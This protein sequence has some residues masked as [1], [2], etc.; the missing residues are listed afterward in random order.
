MINL[1]DS[2][3]NIRESQLADMAALETLYPSAFPDEDLLPLIRKLLAGRNDVLSLVAD[4][5]DGVVGHV[6]FSTCSV[7]GHERHVSM[8]APLAVDPAIQRQGIGAALVQEGLRRLQRKGFRQVL[9]LGDPGYYGR[10]GFLPETS[11]DPPYP[12]PQDWRGAWQSLSLGQGA[13]KLSGVLCV[14]EPW[15]EEALWLP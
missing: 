10:F 7:S 13:V 2:K 9:V 11:V 15:R 14:P 1:M 12:L 8:L 5:S 3:I 6:A 4:G